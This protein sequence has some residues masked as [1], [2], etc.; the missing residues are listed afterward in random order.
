MNNKDLTKIITALKDLNAKN[1]IE[2]TP[3][4]LSTQDY[5]EEYLELIEAINTTVQQA[6]KNAEYS[7]KL[8]SIINNII[9]SGMWNM[10]FNEKGEIIKVTWS[11]TFRN[12]LG[13]HDEKEF[14]NVLESWSDRLHPDH[15]EKILAS[16]WDAVAGN[17]YYDVE[18]LLKGKDGKY[19]WYRATGELER[20]DDGT[21]KIFVGT[22]V[23]IN[24]KKEN[25]EL[26]EASLR[27]R[28]ANEAK[29]RFLSH[30]SHDIRTPIN[31]ILGMVTIGELYP[32]DLKIQNDCRTKIRTITQHLLS[33]IN[34]ILD[35]S[36][37]ESV[38]SDCSP[39][40]FDMNALYIMNQ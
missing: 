39:A 17:S 29:T 28:E 2:E 4:L 6:S 18:Y 22:F 20:R 11:D 30:I 25:D 10:E 26:R 7:Q 9:H 1:T 35:L 5:S 33:L 27:E 16:F 15:K 12:M 13:F 24:I 36:K 40:P 21:P 8:L 3:S 32:N 14:P 19:N 31:G 23:D 38:I 37:L 34:N